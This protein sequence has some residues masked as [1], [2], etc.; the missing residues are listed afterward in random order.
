MGP[1]AAPQ[2]RTEARAAGYFLGQLS[3]VKLPHWLLHAQPRGR[4]GGLSVTGDRTWER[5]ISHRE[6]CG[7]AVVVFLGV[8]G[9]GEGNPEMLPALNPP[10]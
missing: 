4:C 7:A 1:P 5:H 2:G 6:V 10:A 3:R 8:G 9:G